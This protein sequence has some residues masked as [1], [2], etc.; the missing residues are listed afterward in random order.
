MRRV[1]ESS[2]ARWGTCYETSRAL[3]EPARTGAML[4]VPSAYIA[5][6]LGGSRSNGWQGHAG[7]C[8][9]PRVE[10]AFPC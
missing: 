3:R 1:S 10:Q 2:R 5:L 4:S 7:D 6:R 8:L 9:G